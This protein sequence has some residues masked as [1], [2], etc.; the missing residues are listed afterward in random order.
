MGYYYD[1]YIIKDKE[2]L[3]LMRERLNELCE[4]AL[5]NKWFDDSFIMEMCEVLEKTEQLTA[6]QK[7]GIN[8]IYL[9]FIYKEKHGKDF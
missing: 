5:V 8:N 7:L 9:K 3:D 6:K 1:N 4:W 2:T